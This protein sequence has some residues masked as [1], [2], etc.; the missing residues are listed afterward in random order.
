FKKSTTEYKRQSLKETFMKSAKNKDPA[1]VVHVRD[2][3]EVRRSFYQDLT[4]Q[5]QIILKDTQGSFCLQ[6]LIRRSFLLAIYCHRAGDSSAFSQAG[7]LS[8]RRERLQLRT[9]WYYLQKQKRRS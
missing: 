7:C 3:F 9:G 6:C 8:F 1:H 4:D 2:F 5:R